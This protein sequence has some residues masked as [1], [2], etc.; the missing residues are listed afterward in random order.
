MTAE[1]L[2]IETRFGA[3]GASEVPVH[4]KEIH[5]MVNA[6]NLSAAGRA[7]GSTTT[8]GASIVERLVTKL[9]RDRGTDSS[10]G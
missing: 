4:R 8:P 10:N 7:G 1:S 2:L 6:A 3:F 5:Q 9:R